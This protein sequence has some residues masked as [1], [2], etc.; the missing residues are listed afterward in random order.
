MI[1]ETGEDVTFTTVKES[2]TFNLGTALTSGGVTQPNPSSVYIIS[3]SGSLAMAVNI[4]PN[5]SNT[6]TQG[7]Q[8]K[9]LWNCTMTP[10]GHVISIC[11]TDYT[12]ILTGAVNTVFLLIYDGTNWQ[13]YNDLYDIAANQPD[14][15]GYAPLT[16]PT[17]TG[18]VA[19]PSISGT[20]D[21]STKPAPT[22]FV[23]ACLTALGISNYAPLAS[24]ALTG[25]PTAP[26]QSS[27]DNTTKIATTAFVQAVI[28]ALVAAFTQPKILGSSAIGTITGGTG[29]GTAPTLSVTGNDI[30]FQ[31][32]ITTGSTPATSATICTVAFGTAYTAAPVC[33]VQP[34]NANAIA[35]ANAAQPLPSESTTGI[36]LISGGTALS[37]STTYVF[38]VIV[39]G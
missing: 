9:I 7:T 3:G 4:T 15:S 39:V 29:A 21:N 26:T 12:A 18:T 19:V 24:P 8:F 37:A 27:T 28:N 35:L 11:G 10:A 13:V 16:S 25:S 30:G 31:V 34:R 23:Q 36:S 20:S 14:L 32:T 22:S 2:S 38:N 1:I 5:A 6:Y 33:V 17:F